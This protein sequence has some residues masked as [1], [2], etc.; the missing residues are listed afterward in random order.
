ME[1]GIAGSSLSRITRQLATGETE[2]RGHQGTSHRPR[3]GTDGKA[4][5]WCWEQLPGE[6]SSMR[7]GLGRC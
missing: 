1:E 4:G 2:D 7:S 3:G 6:M 5:P